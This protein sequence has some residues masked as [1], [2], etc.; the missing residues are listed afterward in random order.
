MGL[1]AHTF[2]CATLLTGLA[3]T[4]LPGVTPANRAA[5]AGLLLAVL[6]LGVGKG[7]IR[8][9]AS[10]ELFPEEY[11]GLRRYESRYWQLAPLIPWVMLVNFL[12]AGVARRIE[13]R[14]TCYELKSREDVRVLSRA[15]Y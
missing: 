15:E 14:G 9:V 4:V 13:W 8:T 6:L 7:Y 3:L 10:R 1:A 12:I 5:V 11:G 2:Y